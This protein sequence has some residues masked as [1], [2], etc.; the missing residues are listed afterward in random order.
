MNSNTAVSIGVMLTTVDGGKTWQSPRADPPIGEPIRFVTKTQGWLAGGPD[1]QLFR[2]DDGGGSWRPVLVK[3]PS[4]MQSMTEAIYDL[5]VFADK[6]CGVLPVTYSGA[7]GSGLSVLLFATT[8]AGKTWKPDRILSKLPE[9]YGGMPFPSAIADS[10][11][12]TAFVSAKGQLRLSQLG[13]SGGP[14]STVAA[15]DRRLSAVDALTF[16]TPD[17]GWVL[18]DGELLST[19]DAGKTWAD[20]TPGLKPAPTTSL[21][22]QPQQESIV[23]EVGLTPLATP[24]ATTYASVHLGFDM[25]RVTTTSSMQKWWNSSM[26]SDT[27]IYLPGSANRS[28]DPNLTASWVSAVQAQGWGLVPIWF[29]LQAPTAVCGD[30]QFTSEFSSVVATATTQGTQEADSAAAAAAALGIGDTVIYHDIENYTPSSKCSPAVQAFLS[31]WVAELHKN[32]YVAGVYG[33]PIP[34]N[35]DFSEVSP[36]LDDIWIAKTPATGKPPQVTIWG[37]SPLC[38]PYSNPPCNMW[39]SNQRIHQF[40]IDQAGVK[41]GGVTLTIDDNIVDASVV[42]GTHVSKNYNYLFTEIDYPGGTATEG[43]SLSDMGSSAFINAGGEP[44]QIVG[45]YNSEPSLGFQDSGGTFTQ[46]SY[47]SAYQTWANGINNAAQIAGYYQ[48]NNHGLSLHAF[49]YS[50]GSFSSF[51]YPNETGTIFGSINDDGQIVGSFQNS[52]H[53]SEG[54]L[55][56]QGVFGPPLNYPGAAM[57]QPTVVNGSTQI[58]GTYYDAGFNT[59]GFIDLNGSFTSFNYP[60]TTGTTAALGLNNNSQIVGLYFDSN[61]KEHGFLYDTT[62]GIFTTIDYPSAI[63]T[64]A[65]GINDAGEIVGFYDDASGR[66]GFIAT[67]K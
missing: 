28:K 43:L 1:N 2:T 32:G 21:Q 40:L 20:I 67:P 63:S 25:T 33:N 14:S 16:S 47:P 53:V 55:Y 36:T 17:S 58:V 29:G 37:L 46:I 48:I 60:G 8:D 6:C 18:V 11:L 38:D 42:A 24:T 3:A 5:P 44:G 65:V 41:F 26:Y 61:S 51:D 12:I 35:T 45:I 34:A 19:V 56:N 62:A 10:A 59:Y 31:A 15:I 23:A 30:T 7:E 57:T 27:G 52:S 4:K 9:I 49:L 50:N 64:A 22:A 39:D 13:P 54:F 66:H